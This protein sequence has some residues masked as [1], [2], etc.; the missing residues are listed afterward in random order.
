MTEEYAVSKIIVDNYFKKLKN[1]LSCDV[2]VVGGGPAG[3]VCSYILAKN[4]IKVALF[5]RKASLGGGIWGGGM[6][7]NFILVQK[8]LKGMFKEFNINYEVVDNR[9]LV[10]GAPELVGSLLFSVCKAGVEIFNFISAEDLVVKKNRVCGLVLNWTAVEMAKLHVDP[11]NMEAKY[12]VDATGHECSVT[13][14]LIERK[15]VKL[16]LVSGIHGE[17]FMN[18]ELGEREVIENSKEVF[19]G[20]F[21]AGMSANAVLGGHRMGPIFGGMMLS[22]KKVAES[23]IKKL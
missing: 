10:T 19:P 13:K 7:F 12:V 18:V 4:N 15:G 1:M 2:A 16:E 22:G 23:L 8:E 20:L 6:M 9:Y 17:K 3:L 11:L 5:E 21:V 14:K